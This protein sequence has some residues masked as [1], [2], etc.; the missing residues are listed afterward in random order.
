MDALVRQRA[1][2]PLLVV[3]REDDAVALGDVGAD[4]AERDDVPHA[5]RPQR[6]HDRLAGALLPGEEIRLRRVERLEDVDGVGAAERLGQVGRIG[7]VAGDRD[8]PGLGQRGQP[9]GRAAQ[10]P[11][12]LAGRQQ[13]PHD[14]A[15]DL[16]GRGHHGDHGALAL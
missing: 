3:Q 5:G 12:L 10:C 15:A 9:L 7:R 4:A 1:Q 2:P 8:R 16:P 13:L 11:H 6:R 14:L